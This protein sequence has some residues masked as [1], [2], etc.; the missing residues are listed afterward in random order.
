MY[1]KNVYALVTFKYKHTK[2]MDGPL[3]S[4]GLILCA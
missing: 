2:S 4:T 1:F 3:D